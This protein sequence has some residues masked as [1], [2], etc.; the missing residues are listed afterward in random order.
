[1]AAMAL[2]V[3]VEQGKMQH[4]QLLLEQQWQRQQR[5]QL[6]CCDAAV[7]AIV[8]CGLHYCVEVQAV[9]RGGLLC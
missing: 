4:Q 3:L 7:A 1:M 6:A 5:L 9:L 8:P 2:L